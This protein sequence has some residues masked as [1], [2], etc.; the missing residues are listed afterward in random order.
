VTLLEEAQISG[1]EMVPPTV[2]TPDE[3]PA[4]RAGT[5]RRAVRFARREPALVMSL[6]FLTALLVCVVAPG[7][8]APGD[9]SAVDTTIALRSPSA[10][11]LFGTDQ[12]GRDVLVRVVHGARVSIV[13]GVLATVLA[14]VVGSLLGLVAGYVG[15]F[16]DTAVM[17]L[18]NVMLSFPT[19][20][21]A[22]A[23]IAALGSG[24]TKV[25]V[26]VGIAFI[27][28]Y[29]RVV[30]AEVLSVRERLYIEAARASGTRTGRT[31]FRHVLPNTAGPIL[32]MATVGIGTVL[33]AAAAL[34]F[35]G[36]GP[37][38]PS[39][40]WGALVTDGR[41][42]VSHA[43]WIS[44]LPGVVLLLTVLSINITGQWHRSRLGGHR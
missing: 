1:V 17:W 43:W 2:A 25:A 13:A 9:P 12:Y 5:F 8:V 28:H 35:I 7:V 24:A 40:E 22:L 3:P 34:S 27:P 32:V 4:G 44:V 38:S 19:F 16:V 41:R 23:I 21:L 26:A 6:L 33:L 20:L 39:P 42:F 11:H 29:A 31:I 36:L 14:A 30:R 37:A 15:R 10:S 18:V